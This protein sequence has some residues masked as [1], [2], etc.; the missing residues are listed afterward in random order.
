MAAPAPPFYTNKPKGFPGRGSPFICGMRGRGRPRE[1]AAA[2]CL[3]VVSTVLP[4]G[5]G[6][7]GFKHADKEIPPQGSR[8]DK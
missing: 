2:G 3:A 4:A 5:G 8:R 7:E 1:T 6:K